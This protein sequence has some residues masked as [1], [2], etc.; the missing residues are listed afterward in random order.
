MSRGPCRE[1]GPTLFDDLLP[2]RGHKGLDASIEAIAPDT[3]GKILFTSGSTG[4]PKGVINTQRM[5]AAN[6]QMQ[7]E[8]LPIP[9]AATGRGRLDAVEPHLRRQSDF[10][11]VLYNGGSYYIDDGRPVPGQFER[12]VRNLRDIKPNY[13][14]NVPRHTNS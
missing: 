2:R 1:E 14:F 6:Q 9:R 10:G 5:F 13:Y 7:L 3:I 4:M 12:T 11:N 8:M